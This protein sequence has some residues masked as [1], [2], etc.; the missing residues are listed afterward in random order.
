MSLPGKPVDCDRARQ[1]VFAWRPRRDALAGNILITLAVAA[2]FGMFVSFVHIRVA[3]AQPWAARKASVIHVTG[4]TDGRA[5]RLKAR[6]SGPFPSRF[7]PAQWHQAKSIEQSAMEALAWKPP[8]YAPTLREL[9]EESPAPVR[10]PSMGAVVLPKPPPPAS[11]VVPPKSRPVPVL[12]PLSGMAASVMPDE[13]PVFED[14]SLKSTG[15]EPW[16]FLVQLDAAGHVADCVS[17]AGGDAPGPPALVDW[18]RRVAFQP[19]PR[20]SS[21][22]I[23]VSLSFINQ[24]DGADP[25]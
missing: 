11:P 6:E 16:R 25:E 10:L 3:P 12:A 2:A 5:L 9:P 20:Q 17:L 22:W 7:E 23:G 4:D 18:L 21:R 13:L 8:P 14:V 1:W 24:V 15:P 19:D